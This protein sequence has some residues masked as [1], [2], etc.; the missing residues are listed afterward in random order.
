MRFLSQCGLRHRTRNFQMNNAVTNC[1][2][3]PKNFRC[4]YLVYLNLT[5][6]QTNCKGNEKLRSENR[7]TLCR[8]RREHSKEI[9]TCRNRQRCS[10]ERA[11]ALPSCLRVPDPPAPDRKNSQN[12]SRTRCRSP[13]KRSQVGGSPRV[14]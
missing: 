5:S 3:T 12:N 9:F 7:T 13:L 14:R 8:S 4:V 6:I 11:N 2:F 1:F 10:R